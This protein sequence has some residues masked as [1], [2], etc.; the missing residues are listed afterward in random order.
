M[1]TNPVAFGAYSA[2]D[3][4][5]KTGRGDVLVQCSCTF[6]D[7][8]EFSYGLDVQSGGSGSVSNRRMARLG[9]SDT[10][11]YQL[12]T[13]APGISAWVTPR[14]QLFL[15]A[16]YGSG[17]TVYVYG[18]VAPGQAVAAGSYTDNLTVVITF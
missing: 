9:G 6:L 8:V 3:P 18:R 13:E 10:L 2:T 1:T 16:D 17:Q 5:A 7:C 4:A 11:Q 14:T 12:Y 15:L